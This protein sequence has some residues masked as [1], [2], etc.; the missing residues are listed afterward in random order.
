MQHILYT[1]QY[2][3]MEL[4]IVITKMPEWGWQKFMSNLMLPVF[5]FAAFKGTVYIKSNRFYSVS[6]CLR[7]TPAYCLTRAF[8]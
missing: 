3:L 1:L 2:M 8:M 5:N 4:M 6:Q 7:K